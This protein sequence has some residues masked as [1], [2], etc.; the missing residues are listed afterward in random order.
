MVGR[1]PDET[2]PL[3][4]AVVTRSKAK[5]LQLTQGQNSTTIV[6]S[7]KNEI[8]SSTTVEEVIKERFFF[9]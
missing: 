7:K 2:P 9:P 1:V 6:P 4:G 3:A 8:P 5:K